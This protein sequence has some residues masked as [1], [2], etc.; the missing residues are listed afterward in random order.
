MS[1]RE[2]RGSSSLENEASRATIFGLRIAR[3]S[4]IWTIVGVV[5]A[6]VGLGAAWAAPGGSAGQDHSQ[7]TTLNGN[8]GTVNNVQGDQIFNEPS[9]SE[10]TPEQIRQNSE[11]FRKVEPGPTG[12]WVFMVVAFPQLGAKVRSSGLASG[13]Q[14]GSAAFNTAVWADC[15]LDTGFVP[16][17]TGK[18]VW[19]RVRWPST[20]PS[21]AFMNTS[22]QDPSVGWIFG[23]L[24][25]PAGHNG[26]IPVC[27]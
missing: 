20:A 7:H 1:R 15:R 25:V 14:I 26:D 27:H 24:I 18:S 23:D 13:Y 10:P 22:A 16:D 21:S 4:L 9:S 8:G 17:D 5:V 6:L 2:P 11:R 19:F 12:P 3:K